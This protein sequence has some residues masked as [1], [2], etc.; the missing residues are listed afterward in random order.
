MKVCRLIKGKKV[1]CLYPLK[2][3]KRKQAKENGNER[4]KKKERTKTKDKKTYSKE[5][6]NRHE[7]EIASN[8]IY[9]NY[10]VHH[11]ILIKMFKIYFTNY[12]YGWESSERAK[13]NDATQNIVCGNKEKYAES[14]KTE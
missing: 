2:S 1:I 7:M 9:L 12:L 4:R 8:Y 10:V 14:E 6:R 5:K 3:V 11:F 13:K